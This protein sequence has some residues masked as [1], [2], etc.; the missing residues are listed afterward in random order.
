MQEHKWESWP[1][2]E[3]GMHGQASQGRYVY[4]GGLVLPVSVTDEKRHNIWIRSQGGCKV[5]KGEESG[6]RQDSRGSPT[7]SGIQKQDTMVQAHKAETAA[8][9][10]NRK[11]D[12]GRCMGRRR[13]W[14]YVGGGTRGAHRMSGLASQWATLIGGRGRRT[15]EKQWRR[16]KAVLGRN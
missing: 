10:D 15:N 7:G 2:E 12:N 6:S 13:C 16:P 14:W 9:G 11:A 5:Y 1:R 3:Q 4:G 8:G